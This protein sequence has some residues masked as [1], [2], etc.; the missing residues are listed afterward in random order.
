[1]IRFLLRW[2][3]SHR[4]RHHGS[5]GSQGGAIAVEQSAPPSDRQRPMP[6]TLD[7]GV[8]QGTEQ[9]VRD[10]PQET[11]DRRS[12]DVSQVARSLAYMTSLVTT[13]VGRMERVEQAQTSSSGRR[14]AATTSAR[15]ETPMGERLKRVH[16]AGWIFG[17]GRPAESDEPWRRRQRRSGRKTTG[18][19]G[20]HHGW[21]FQLR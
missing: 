4:V 8:G 11:M 9:G 13:L 17:V 3:K 14:T 20:Q 15:M 19:Y 18:N 10:G 2:P 12:E 21:N 1:M 6:M 16:L 5:H 7:D